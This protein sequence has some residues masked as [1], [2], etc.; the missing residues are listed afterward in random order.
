MKI[1]IVG[2]GSIGNKHLH[3]ICKVL[4]E[5]G[6]PYSIDALRSQARKLNYEKIELINQEYDDIAKLPR[7]Y[8]IIFITNPTSK[9]FETIQQLTNNTKHM[10]IEKPLF[11]ELKSDLKN[12]LLHKSN[13]YYVACPLRHKAIMKYVKKIVTEEKIYSAR[14][15]SSSYLPEWRR[16]VDYRHVYSAQKSLGGGV[17][18][19]LIHEW[20]YITHLFGMPEAVHGF[21]GQYSALEIDSEDIAVYI[22]KYSD[23]IVEIHLDYFGRTPKRMLELY[24]ENYT[25]EVNLLSNTIQYRGKEEREITFEADDFYL[26]EIKYF[27][28]LVDGKLENL[29]PI[30]HAH[31]VLALALQK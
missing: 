23:K 12:L 9:H 25:I 11:E 7:D 15:I 14:A 24:C 21:S 26:E 1:C 19:D 28:D 6:T 10:F 29:N 2:L 27:F 5:K 17:A 31:E 8:D 20:D 30:E 4:E 18:L 13:I 22:G 16:G 3:N